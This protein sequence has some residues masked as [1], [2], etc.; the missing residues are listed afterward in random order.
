MEDGSP[1]QRMAVWFI[2]NEIWKSEM[3]IPIK[4]TGSCEAKPFGRS[5]FDIRVGFPAE[6]A[7]PIANLRSCSR[8][9][10][11]I[12]AVLHGLRLFGAMV[13]RIAALPATGYKGA[14][15]CKIQ[16]SRS[17]EEEASMKLEWA[18]TFRVE[19]LQFWIQEIPFR[20]Y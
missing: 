16:Q 15:Y 14:V 17:E 1:E 8:L 20:V 11:R 13:C 18:E 6:R 4:G 12:S 10:P 9:A 2:L 7:F 3:G 19:T 5:R